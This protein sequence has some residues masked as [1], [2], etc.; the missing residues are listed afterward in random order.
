MERRYR[1]PVPLLGVQLRGRHNPF[2]IALSARE[3]VNVDVELEEAEGA[4]SLRVEG[5]PRASDALRLALGAFLDELSSRLEQPLRAHV[6]YETLRYHPAG[7]YAV[8]TYALV[9]AVV[10][11]GGY[12]MSREEIAEAANS[13]D[14]DAGVDLD[15][16]DGLR[17]ALARG[18]SLVYRRGEDPVEISLEGGAVELVG[19]EKLGDVIEDKLDEE[20]HVALSRLVGMTVATVAR[21]IVEK[22]WRGVREAWGVA[23]RL[24]NGVYYALFGVE[25]PSPGCKWTPGIHS[26][27]AVCLGSGL[28]ERLELA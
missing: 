22:G 17:A 3:L 26:V 5:E 2:I 12:D 19:E 8:L 7:L 11:E 21:R 28:G 23:S 15:Y 27:F 10:E 16:L 13:I 4:P 24:E 25:P 6:Y 20:V 14:S 18:K 1:L 9:E